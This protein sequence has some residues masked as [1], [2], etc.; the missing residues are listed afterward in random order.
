MSSSGK[1]ILTIAQI[2]KRDRDLA[3][4]AKTKAGSAAALGRMF[5]VSKQAAGGWGRAEPIPRHVRPRLE[6]YVKGRRD[7]EPPALHE[8]VA[9]YMLEEVREVRSFTSLVEA[10]RKIDRHDERTYRAAWRVLMASAEAIR[11]L[12]GWTDADWEAAITKD[13]WKTLT[14]QPEED[15]IRRALE[16]RGDRR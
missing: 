9:P 3:A 5:G 11:A 8:P 16:E 6:D 15:T 12:A 7:G 2:S 1:D 10:L 4:A 13:H 14:R